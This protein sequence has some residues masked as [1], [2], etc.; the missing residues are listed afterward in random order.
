MIQF[1]STC[2]LLKQS[3]LF[4]SFFIATTLLKSQSVTYYPA[5]NFLNYSVNSALS[6][7]STGGM[8]N[9]GSGGS[10]NYSIP[11]QVPT[12]I[13][14]LTPSLSVDY[15]SHSGNGIAGFGFGLSATSSISY[16]SKGIYY[17]GVVSAA[18]ITSGAMLNLDG[19][20]LLLTSGTYGQNGAVYSTAS[21]SF[22][23]ITST[24][25]SGCTSC[26]QSFTV[27][28]RNGLTMEYGNTSDSRVSG[29]ASTYPFMWMLNK[30][31]DNYGNYLTYTYSS[32]STTGEVYLTEIKYFTGGSMYANI[33]FNYLE[34]SDRN[35]ITEYSSQGNQIHQLDKKKLLTSIQVYSEGNIV[36][37][38][39]F[40]YSY[41]GFYSFLQEIKVKGANGTYLN[42]TWFNYG[43]SSPVNFQNVSNTTANTT[44]T[45]IPLDMDGD[46][47]DELFTAKYTTNLWGKIYNNYKIYKVNGST[48]A[49]TQIA[50]GTLPTAETYNGVS[51]NMFINFEVF[52]MDGDG[53]KDIVLERKVRYNSKMYLKYVSVLRL[54]APTTA[55]MTDYPSINTTI[56]LLNNTNLLNGSFDNNVF[57]VG[58]FDGDGK[59]DVIVNDTLKS[60]ISFPA[61]SVF[62]YD[63]YFDNGSGSLTNFL[64][65][66]SRT[67]NYSNVVNADN[68]DKDDL[69][70]L[71]YPA[72]YNFPVGHPFTIF[73]NGV[74]QYVAKYS[75]TNTEINPIDN[76]YFIN[77]DFNGDGI[78]DYLSHYPDVD[79]Y[80]KFFINYNEGKTSD[81][82]F[83]F[84][85]SDS[86]INFTEINKDYETTNKTQALLTG[87]YNGD[88]KTDIAFFYKASGNDNF[89]I[90]YSTGISFTRE[91]YNFSVTSTDYYYPIRTADFNGDG[92]DDILHY[93]KATG[94]YYILYFKP[95]GK[96]RLLKKV[97]DGLLNV[98]EFTYKLLTEDPD[99]SFTNVAGQFPLNEIRPAMYVVDKTKIPDGTGGTGIETQYYYDNYKI[100]GIAG[101]L[102]FLSRAQ[103]NLVTTNYSQTD[104]VVYDQT[105]AGDNCL[106]LPA[107]SWSCMGCTT[108]ST[109]ANAKFKTIVTNPTSS[110]IESAT[111]KSYKIQPQG[112]ISTDLVHGNTTTVNGITYDAY[113]N[114]T[115]QTTTVSDGS[116]STVVTVTTAAANFTAITPSQIPSV[117]NGDITTS[118]T[119]NG[120]SAFTKT[121]TTTYNTQGKLTQTVSGSGTNSLSTI[122]TYDPA[123][124]NLLTTNSSTPSAN[125][126]ARSQAFTYYGPYKRFLMEIKDKDVGGDVVT[127]Y[128]GYDARWEKP[129]TITNGANPTLFTTSTFDPNFG[130]LVSS[131]PSYWPVGTAVAYE[132][133]YSPGSPTNALYYSKVTTPDAP[134]V[135]NYFD[136][137]GRTLKTVSAGDKTNN[138][139]NTYTIK[140]ELLQNKSTGADGTDI[141]TDYTNYDSY[142]RLLTMTISPGI[143]SAIYAYLDGTNRVTSTING[144]TK[145]TTTDATGNL[146]TAVDPYA[147]LTYTYH[148]NGT[149]KEVKNGTP[150]QTTTI[151]ANGFQST[152]VDNNAGT[153]SYEYNGFG[154]LIKQTDANND[155]TVLKYDAFGRLSGTVLSNSS[156]QSSQA[157]TPVTTDYF[158]N[159]TG[160]NKYLPDYTDN[161]TT[162]VTYG[163]DTK[164]RNNSITTSYGGTNYVQTTSYDDYGKPTDVTYPGGFKVNYGYSGSVEGNVA[165]IT[166]GMTGG[167]TTNVF[168]ATI[169]AAYNNANQ[170]L[171]YQLGYGAGLKNIANTYEINGLLKTTT[172]KTGTTNYFNYTYGWDLA[173]GNL[174]SRTDG[175]HSLTETFGYDIP[176]QNLTSITLGSNPANI[177]NY[178]ANGNIL[179]K[180]DAGVATAPETEAYK[181][182]SG[183]PNAVTQIKQVN[184]SAT[185]PTPSAIS[186]ETQNIKY[187]GFN[188]P[189]TIEHTPYQSSTVNKL[190]TYSYGIGTQRIKSEYR[191]NGTLKNT[192]LYF[193]DYEKHID[194]VTGIT[195]DVY[196]INT[197]DGLGAVAVNTS[198]TLKYYYAVKDHLGSIMTLTDETGAINT[199][200][201][202]DAWGRVR[203][204]NNWTYGAFSQPTN[205][206]SKAGGNATGWWSRGYTG[207]EHLYTQDLINMNGRMYDPIA[208][209][210]LSPDKYVQNTTSLQGFNRYSYVLNN[211]LKY[212]D[213]SGQ[214]LW[215][216]RGES[217]LQ[218]QPEGTGHGSGGGGGLRGGSYFGLDWMAAFN[219]VGARYGTFA[220]MG[221]NT[222]SINMNILI[223]QREAEEKAKEKQ[224]ST[225]YSEDGNRMTTNSPTMIRSIF[226]GLD[227]GFSIEELIAPGVTIYGKNGQYSV[228]QNSYWNAWNFIQGSLG[229]DGASN[230]Q[231]LIGKVWNSGFMRTLVPDM[232]SAG[233]N[234]GGGFIGGSK[235]N[236]SIHLVTRGKDAGVHYTQTFTGF[237]GAN[238]DLSVDYGGSRYLGK[239]ENIRFS[240]FLGSGKTISGDF[241]EGATLS[242]SHKGFESTWFSGSL[243]TGFSLGGYAG[244][245][246]TVEGW[247]PRTMGNVIP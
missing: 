68:D 47:V 144:I 103:K 143:S 186:K 171:S 160:A 146:V 16:S 46:G 177:I 108:S 128:G 228:D 129:T 158:Y 21:E 26:P 242:L 166:A 93:N 60:H 35:I 151:D 10:S 7:G 43:E 180:W 152:L 11:I 61:L 154:D 15:N 32:N 96:E 243:S 213:P 119:V 79:N 125:S 237:V 49:L 104:N 110:V 217:Y 48:G 50:T 59:G 127:T 172:A 203:N 193:G 137:Y 147:T 76:D 222:A 150:I 81:N 162:K 65:V 142:S 168:T 134:T 82:S 22:A 207:H 246:W 164:R 208:G 188:Q 240:D 28:T 241:L 181:Y 183:K 140:G 145:I 124:G 232:F 185:D 31:S 121:V 230:S 94:A 156:P 95:K 102:G 220:A 37:T 245:T 111:N 191:E 227:A 136:I 2:K 229:S 244:T 175:L 109:I 206:I 112:S 247:N 234:I 91:T 149:L 25:T 64:T 122:N 98:T 115:A 190:T 215:S 12:G 223:A 90:Y 105:A 55:S 51:C 42:P 198:G 167:T 200:Q 14:G 45:C 73:K 155:Q 33:V 205:S 194:N 163:Y 34:R 72:L 6:V 40:A 120:S 5:T 210:M 92:R 77:G 62:N 23:K 63:L 173:T 235:Y 30:T 106:L 231:G 71:S 70:V 236:Y 132:T 135:T 161:G 86:Y 88:G 165:S 54:T 18:D 117:V 99:Y 107:Q 66:Y 4:F 100:H 131:K 174:S 13:N 196:Y 153:T 233:V 56:P 113:N 169:P 214:L 116:N 85:T 141:T 238:L 20:R 69:L 52:D 239:A 182:T 211:P 133:K 19:N 84:S 159:T 218:E 39:E 80:R 17:D 3:L 130:F 219:Q 9:I 178:G 224:G 212:T 199:E 184:T 189:V 24:G 176:K 58:D 74:G 126:P 201:S 87:D 44:T 216:P 53:R 38:Y 192:I 170:C 202:F 83:N 97:S 67:K 114:V 101:S 29:S 204:P 1:S 75:V 57:Y 89:N 78:M 41:D 148:G 187:N 225:S 221:A 139:T 226:R 209:R 179:N 118:S 138:S 8:I 195:R 27:V 123:N 197:P 157:F 36:R